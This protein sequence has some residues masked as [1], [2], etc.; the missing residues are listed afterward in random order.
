MF[1]A[2][3]IVAQAS[4]SMTIVNHQRARL[5]K[6]H[7]LAPHHIEQE[8]TNHEMSQQALAVIENSPVPRREGESV[9]NYLKRTFKG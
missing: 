1:I 3:I 9:R 6:S 2:N 8:N 4:A 5:L 7:G